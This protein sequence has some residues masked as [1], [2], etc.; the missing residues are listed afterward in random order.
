[1]SVI[2]SL[3]I[4]YMESSWAGLAGFL[5]SLPLSG[6]VVTGYLLARHAAEVYGYGSNITEY[7][8]E[9]G[10]LLCAFVNGF[11]F[12]PIYQWWLARRKSRA[13]EA[14]PT[15]PDFRT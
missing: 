10:F 7:H 6:F 8:T 3:E 12:Y 9:Y 4:M 11:I 5:L 13:V 1:M 2:V 15:P 14:P